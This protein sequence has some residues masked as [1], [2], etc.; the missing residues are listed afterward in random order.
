MD[1]TE[2][3][4][5]TRTTLIAGAIVI[6]GF[7]LSGLSWWFFLLVAAGALG[8]GILRETGWLSD[9]DEFQR[10][11]D[12][13]AGY[14][15]FLTV[16][17]LAFVLVAYIRSGERNVEH[18]AAQPGRRAARGTGQVL[19]RGGYGFVCFGLHVSIAR[20]RLLIPGRE[21]GRD[22]ASA[23]SGARHSASRSRFAH[24]SARFVSIGRPKRPV[25]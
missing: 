8:P 14:H 5:P 10:Q 4:Q 7:A 3:W 22:L 19:Q 20:G 1:K 24:A 13:R 11:A 6:A 12:H 25:R 23:S 9:K 16:G 2:R 17:L 18:A 15:A 21:S